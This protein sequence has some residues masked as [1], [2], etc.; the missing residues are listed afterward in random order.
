M[1]STPH[2]TLD[3]KS[4]LV[5]YLVD[6]PSLSR[7]ATYGGHRGQDVRQLSV[8]VRR[9]LCVIDSLVEGSASAGMLRVLHVRAESVAFDG[10]YMLL[11]T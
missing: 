4:H 11:V 9:E 3:C 8:L 1:G 5:S 10:W 2:E 7:F 6:V